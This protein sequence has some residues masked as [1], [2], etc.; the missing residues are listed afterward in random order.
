MLF[1]AGVI[2]ALCLS[3]IA[4]AKP[5]LNQRAVF[6][7]RASVPKHSHHV[8]KLFAERDS[9]PVVT[10]TDCVT[11]TVWVTAGPDSKIYGN[12]VYITSTIYEPYMPT[13]TDQA[14]P[15]MTPVDT[16]P[17]N[18]P[19]VVTPPIDTNTNTNTPPIITPP[20]D[21]NTN[22]PIQTPAT[23]PAVVLAPASYDID[24]STSS[25]TD[26]S[27]GSFTGQ[28]TFYEPGLGACGIT[29][30]TPDLIVA[31]S[32]SLFD[33]KGTANPNENPFCN[34]KIRVFRNGQSVNV[35]VV[36]R[37]T[38][39]AHYDLDFSPAA[40]NQ[41]AKEVEGRVGISWDWIN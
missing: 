41:I 10:V 18:A 29:N 1:A 4:S 16:N 28:G 17:V 19:P 6:G 23:T 31:I 8:R 11:E 34:Q 26:T 35:T 12:T 7:R 33:S 5:L 2:S 37:C 15:D 20:V 22:T 24:V 25:Q 32:Q 27:K 13:A 38:G 21:T 40:F 36:D 3:S 39:C 30:G 9:V 14:H